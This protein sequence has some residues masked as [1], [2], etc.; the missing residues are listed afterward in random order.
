VG[1]GSARPWF[2]P[3]QRYGLWHVTPLGRSPPSHH[4]PHL[5]FQNSHRSLAPHPATIHH[6][7]VFLCLLF[8]S[9]P[10]FS[11]PP[12]DLPP[13]LTPWSSAWCGPRPCCL[14]QRSGHR[15]CSLPRRQPLSPPLPRS[16]RSPRPPSRCSC[17][18]SNQNRSCRRA[19]LVA[20]NCRWIWAHS[21]CSTGGQY[22]DSPSASPPRHHRIR[23][24]CSPQR[25]EWTRRCQPSSSPPS[26]TA[27]TFYPCSPPLHATDFG[28]GYMRLPSDAAKWT[29]ICWIIAFRMVRIVTLCCFILNE[30]CSSYMYLVF[31]EGA[32]TN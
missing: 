6:I 28:E 7:S 16:Q 3:R 20:R 31:E 26:S 32:I 1:I 23:L 12:M 9:P 11:R 27:S 14:W 2:Y 8:L 25:R 5:Q 13:R 4:P 29:M 10:R 24:S 17:R 22:A 18:L 30:F 21:R 15:R 19:P